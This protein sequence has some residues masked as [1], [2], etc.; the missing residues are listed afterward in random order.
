MQTCAACASVSLLTSTP[1]APLRN[2]GGDLATLAAFLLGPGFRT[3]TAFGLF[4]PSARAAAALDTL[5]PGTPS[6]S[7]AD[8][9]RPAAVDSASILGADLASTLAPGVSLSALLWL[10]VLAAPSRVLVDARG[11]P[12]A[13]ATT[14]N[15]L[16]A[17]DAEA[18][19]VDRGAPFGLVVGD[20]QG[21][22]LEAPLVAALAAAEAVWA[23]LGVVW[24]AA[25]VV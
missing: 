17:G 3:P 23:A 25:G 2:A 22:L 8:D 20:A 5:A 10:G 1:A 9:P 4:K 19:R 24:A 15:F 11:D 12:W 14:T 13:G 7:A 6:P 18:P 21:V 16:P